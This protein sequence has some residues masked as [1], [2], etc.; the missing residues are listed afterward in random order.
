MIGGASGIGAG[1]FAG[2]APPLF[3]IPQDM[4]I[5][6]VG[7]IAIGKVVIGEVAHEGKLLIF[8]VMGGEFFLCGLFVKLLSGMGV[9]WP[10]NLIDMEEL[11]RMLHRIYPL[12]PPL[13]AHLRSIIRQHEYLRGEHLLRAGEVG[14]Q[15]LYLRQGLVRSYR[16]VRQKPVSKWFMKEGNICISI[17]SFLKQVPSTENIIALEDCECWGI[18][19]RQLQETYSRFPEFNVHGRLITAD[20]YCWLDDR[21]DS[22]QGQKPEDTFARVIETD[23]EL[24]M[25]VKNKDL[26][27]FLNVSLRTLTDIRKAY[28]EG[29]IRTGEVG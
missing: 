1:H 10:A 6:A 12:S 29:K 8:L 21:Y 24:T 9:H 2:D 14:G 11:I 20:Y 16:L 25:R 7:E 15:I 18:T 13:E 4:G 23:P 22:I 28:K 5:A 17:R 3:F 26:A 27:S 19:H